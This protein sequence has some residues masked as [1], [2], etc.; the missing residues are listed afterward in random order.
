MYEDKEKLERHKQTWLTKK[1][2]EL[3]LQ[4]KERLKKEECRELSNQK[5]INNLILKEYEKPI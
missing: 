4:E 3:I 1:C 2:S 5:I